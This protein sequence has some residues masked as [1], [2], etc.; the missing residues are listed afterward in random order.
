MLVDTP[1]VSLDASVPLDVIV[2][3]DAAEL[4]QRIKARDLSCEEVMRAYLEHIERLNPR[5]NAIVT[6]ADPEQL[7]AQ[8]R[9]RDRQLAR[10]KYLGWMH[11]FPLAAKD[12]AATSGMRTT[13]GSPLFKDFVPNYDSISVERM[14]RAGAIIIGK[15]NTPEFGLGSQTYNEVFGA[16][17]NAY[18]M[19]KTSGG[20]SGGAAV[21]LAL[22]ML[23]VA[24]GSDMMG[25][26]RNPAAYNNVYGFRPSQ[27]RVPLG[28]AVELF[29]QQL[30]TEGPMGRTVN[31]VARL[32]AIQAGSDPRAPI[33]ID[34][35]GGRFDDPLVR[36]FKG[37]RIGWLGDFGGYLA[38]EPGVIDL[39][40]T[41]LKDFE[42]IGC[43]V[44]DVMPD[45]SM[46]QLWQT[47]LT[48]RH[49]LICGSLGPHYAD[50]RKRELLKPEA[51]WEIEGGLH[52]KGDAVYKA[53]LARSAWYREVCRLFEHYDYLILPTA[54]VF[55]FD[56]GSHWPKEI[57]G[58]TMDTYH[59]WMEVVTPATLAGLPAISVPIGFDANGR[60]MGVQILGKPR[61]DFDTLAL[62]HAH[63]LA[64]R[65]VRKHPP[66]VLA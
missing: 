38:T 7:L 13:W 3:L 25:S 41:G 58:R 5:V 32:L 52:L 55:A 46:E 34:H 45:F 66:A 53:S 10:G 8:A 29:F 48:L 54:Q 11:G 59:R 12:L 37:T 2:S 62:A 42:A 15:T 47:W 24:D 28:P 31:D 44:E 21:C 49:W 20:S 4:S 39:C 60:A 61:A 64:T 51:R 56:A 30:S 22:R 57:A 6:L 65:W 63:E 40:E 18:D 35:H 17:R 23:P 19:A 43:E 27:G 1:S 26:L 14:K 16:T 33:A 36:D 9:E 50:G